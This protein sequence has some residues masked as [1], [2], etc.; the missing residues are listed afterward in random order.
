M[1]EH[2]YRILI[3]DDDQ[4]VRE[5]MSIILSSFGTV[6]LAA[7]GA[8]ARKQFQTN[9]YDII[10]LD[11][12]MP[13]T[14]GLVL[15]KEFKEL[16]PR[17]EIIMITHVRE[18]KVAVKAIKSGAFDYIN[19]DFS[20]DEM[21]A[22]IYRV[23]EKLKNNQEVYYLRSEVQRLTDQEFILGH[24]PKMQNIQQILQRAARTSAT[25]LIQGE[26]GTGKE[27]A[28]RFLH[29]HS[30]RANRPFVAV[31]MASIPDNLVESTLFGH[32]KG[33]FT[34][35]LKRGYG[36]FELADGGTLFC[37]EI[38]ELKLE[39]Q[40]KLLR[41]IQ[42]N[43]VERV[44]GDRPIHVDVRIIAATNRDLRSNVEEGKF[45]EDLFYRLNVI[46]IQL[47]PLRQRLE[48]IPVFVQMFLERYNKKYGRSL[49]CSPE[50]LTILSQYDWPGNIRELEN[51]IARLVAIHPSETLLPEDIPIDYHFSDPD[52]LKDIQQGGD[53]LK[54]ATDAFERG[55]IL[56]VLEKEAW[57][58]EKTADKLGVHRKTLEYKI[59]K[60]GLE[61]V[62]EQRKKEARQKK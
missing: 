29:R 26:S 1:S 59:K 16:Q 54:S 4:S 8:E 43:E 12:L 41:V 49:K 36:K 32:E 38:S 57:H 14:N 19:K 53:P 51:L 20:P 52:Q 24:S 46:P 3:V 30:Q 27:L 35:A 21:K 60:L 37:D 55:F 34:G 44:G 40:S 61:S 58:Q 23:I 15:L 11:Y 18:V 47:P 13:D 9:E 5:M 62:I 25:V 42:E 6:D 56:R 22:L 50:A 7:D 33:S 10:L 2:N 39:L 31:N 28:A 45:R 17:T 48:D